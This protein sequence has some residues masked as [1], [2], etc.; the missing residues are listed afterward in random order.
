[1]LS[2]TRQLSGHVTCG[3]NPASCNLTP[4]DRKVILR[5]RGEVTEPLFPFEITRQLDQRGNEFVY[6]GG[7]YDL[8][9]SV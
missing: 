9:K 3:V 8:H 1:M 4:V 7:G 6:N 2:V 5:I